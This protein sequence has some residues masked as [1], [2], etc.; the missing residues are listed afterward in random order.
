[1]VLLFILLVTLVFLSGCSIKNDNFIYGFRE[2]EIGKMPKIYKIQVPEG[3]K[4]KAI[5]IKSNGSNLAL[6]STQ[7]TYINVDSD[8]NGKIPFKITNNSLNG[9]E[10]YALI[11][12]KDYVISAGEV[13]PASEN[14]QFNWIIKGTAIEKIPSSEP[15]FG[16]DGGTEDFNKLKDV[17]SSSLIV[18]P[19]EIPTVSPELARLF[20]SDK[21]L[22]KNYSFNDSNFNDALDL[23]FRDL[24][25][26]AFNDWNKF[27]G[28]D[29]NSSFY[30]PEKRIDGLIFSA[31]PTGTTTFKIWLHSLGRW[32]EA[33]SL[34]IEPTTAQPIIVDLPETKAID[35][36]SFANY[37]NPKITVN[38]EELKFKQNK[39]IELEASENINSVLPIGEK[40]LNLGRITIDFAASPLFELG[41]T[42]SGKSFI[43]TDD[44]PKI[45]M[46]FSDNNRQFTENPDANILAKAIIP[47]VKTEINSEKF[48]IRLI[49]GEQGECI[50]EN[51]ELGKTGE[52]AKPHVKFDWSWNL[53]INACDK[54]IAV[55]N[56]DKYIYCDPAQFSI[57]VLKKIIRAKELAGQDFIRF[58]DEISS[59][60]HFYDYLIED[61]YTEDFQKD[62]D[63]YYTNNVFFSTPNWFVSSETPWGKKY[64]AD[65]AYFKFYNMSNPSNTKEVSAGLYEIVIDFNFSETYGEWV[66]F[67]TNKE[68]VA[69]IIV[70][71]KKIAIPTADNIFY[72][73]PFNANVGMDRIDEDGLAER[74]GYGLGLV[75]DQINLSQG[76]GQYIATKPINGKKT[77]TTSFD[78]NFNTTSLGQRG[79]VLSSGNNSLTFTP[80]KATP[81]IMEISSRQEKAS[82]YY[83]LM[84]DSATLNEPMQYASLWTA[85]AATNNCTTFNGAPFFSKRKDNF[86]AAPCPSSSSK[87]FGFEWNNALQK[88]LFLETQFYTPVNSKFDL[89][90]TCNDDNS[91]FYSASTGI[92]ITRAT[93]A[94]PLNYGPV[95]GA[96]QDVFDLV[97]G[98]KIC[99]SENNMNLSFWW[100]S[101]KI[102]EDLN[103]IKQQIA[104]RFS[105]NYCQSNPT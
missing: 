40:Q 36:I 31:I 32:F 67:S 84:K 5:R 64:F 30:F 21:N 33:A 46:A 105:G 44:S 80:S 98:G 27:E 11:E 78:E 14:I 35:A 24:N 13:I 18:L 2:I 97:N 63:Y 82:A 23:A 96:V 93:Q 53:D 39:V 42:V 75:G 58:R 83:Y 89:Y 10:N 69:K 1:M 68:P 15:Y 55:E 19:A 101:Q 25:E 22:M 6:H 65:P 37:G 34:Q 100:N 79:I 52:K 41:G 49:A 50:S 29:P 92:P 51:G 73:L 20:L 61:A 81:A 70:N 94:L 26:I 57:E 66:F 47:K 56:N 104:S 74:K 88:K 99:V 45:E 8:H 43:L 102:A 12:A 87:N 28:T 38:I 16:E 77:L 3:L 59:L 76:Q 91:V 17:N 48:H 85:F 90:K 60:R 72:H 103:T 71:L 9:T 4:I 86:N 95:I 62:F 7:Y 54:N